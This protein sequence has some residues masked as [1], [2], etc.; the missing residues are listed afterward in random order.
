MISSQN[1]CVVVCV[2]VLACGQ[3]K[4]KQCWTTGQSDFLGHDWLMMSSTN[5]GFERHNVRLIL[6]HEF[7][8]VY[9]DGCLLC[10][11]QQDDLYL[12]LGYDIPQGFTICDV[13]ASR[14]YCTKYNVNTNGMRSPFRPSLPEFRVLRPPSCK[15]P[16]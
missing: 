8:S 3:P 13:E 15:W 16:I 14:F 9:S 10:T 5:G 12:T 2:N 1:G 11:G 4:C 7:L 6:V